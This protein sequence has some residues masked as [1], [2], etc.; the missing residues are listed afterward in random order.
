MSMADDEAFA[1]VKQLDTLNGMVAGQASIAAALRAYGDRRAKDMRDR[2]ALE[3]S[4]RCDY[5][6]CQRAYGLPG[7]AHCEDAAAILALP[8]REE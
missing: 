6:L 1:L 7:C 5:P 2:A 8:L 3:C 4:M